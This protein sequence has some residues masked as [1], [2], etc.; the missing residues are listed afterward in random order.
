VDITTP[1]LKDLA[2]PF[3]K[4]PTYRW[5]TDNAHRFGFILSCPRNNGYYQFEPWHWRFVGKTLAK[6]LHSENK[7]F[8]DLTQ[9]DID[10]YL[11]SIF[12]P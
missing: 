1:K 2:V 5:L 4:D 12:D 10:S 11:I 7:N 6:K 8:Y 9:R 3:E